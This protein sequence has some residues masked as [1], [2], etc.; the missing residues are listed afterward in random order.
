[1]WTAATDTFSLLL[2]RVVFACEVWNW[3][4]YFVLMR[5]NWIWNEADYAEDRDGKKLGP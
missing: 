5:Q 1:M 3:S 2:G 4:S